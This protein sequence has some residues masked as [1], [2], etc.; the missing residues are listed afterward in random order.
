MNI[1]IRITPMNMLL[2]FFLFL[3]LS[4]ALIPYGIDKVA[5]LFYLFMVFVLRG[6]RFVIKDISMP[7]IFIAC[8]FGFLLIAN[9]TSFA[10]YPHGSILFFY[11]MFCLAIYSLVENKYSL[12]FL[13]HVLYAILT[14]LVFGV[15]FWFLNRLGLSSD[16]VTSV[17]GML[18]SLN[19]TW[20]LYLPLLVLFY[21]GVK[22]KYVY[23]ILTFLTLS[24]GF[25]FISS[26]FSVNDFGT[27][28]SRWDMLNLASDFFSNMSVVNQILGLP[29]YDNYYYT[30][31][32]REFS[33]VE[34][35]VFFI[36]INYGY[37]GLFSYATFVALVLFYLKSNTML[38]F[39]AS[40]YY[41][42]VPMLTHEFYSI[43]FFFVSAVI[44]SMMSFEKNAR[45]YYV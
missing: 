5:I 45:N 13:R 31:H 41:L 16:Y 37:F 19:R 12:N 38:L 10:L 15:L 23:F 34:N 35:G 39:F 40:Y 29:Y 44:L 42:I 6:C 18:L 33:L 27:L 36:L 20:L 25:Y 43:S 11:Y 22:A 26:N 3:S 32:G 24:I 17:V 28:K 1:V 7:F 9:S 8:V 30:Y 14:L 2:S 21:L 4:V